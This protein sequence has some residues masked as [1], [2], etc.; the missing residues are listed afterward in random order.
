M[1]TQNNLA[2][3][4]IN[5]KFREKIFQT[6]SYAKFKKQLVNSNC[7]LCALHEGRTQVVVDRGN[8][9]ASIMMVGEGPGENEDLQGQ[10]FVGRA[11]KLLDK[12]CLEAG[13]DNTK[14]VLIGNVVRCRPPGNRAP[15][16]E[17]AIMCLPYL[18][19]QIELVNPKVIVLLGATALKHLLP[20]MKN[21]A[22]KDVVGKFIEGENF[23]GRIFF[24]CY[25]PAYILRDPRKK[26]LMIEML[27]KLKASL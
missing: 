16:K 19:K 17:E 20:E 13:I 5:N 25:H 22:V 7:K 24:M 26:P 14:D 2:T 18:K 3:M 4:Q 6:H 9:D 8:S 11:G 21:V 23:P 10:A 15:K 1:Q 27:Q 12:M